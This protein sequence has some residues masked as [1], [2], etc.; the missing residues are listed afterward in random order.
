MLS[1]NLLPRSRK[2]AARIPRRAVTQARRATRALARPSARTASNRTK[3]EK[4]ANFKPSKAEIQQ[5]NP[6]YLAAV[7]EFGTAVRAF[8]KQDYRKAAE[9]FEKLAGSEVREVAE[10]AET[11]LR[12]CRQRNS[13]SS[14]ALRSAEEHYAFG[15]ACLNAGEPER[16]LEHLYKADKLRPN[17]DHVRYAL[18]ASYALRGDV[19]EACA[20]LEAA[21][22]LHPENRIYARRDQDFQGVVHDPRFRRLLYPVRT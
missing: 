12:F 11:H 19:G 15:V 5:P 7:K 21:V 14:P 17:Q 4:K 2:P 3:Y 10:R 8:H 1:R 6:Q 20:Q 9:I 22:A 18:A 16:A 13:H